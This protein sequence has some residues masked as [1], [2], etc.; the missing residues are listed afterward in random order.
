MRPTPYNERE[1]PNRWNPRKDKPEEYAV[2][3]RMLQADP[4]R[5]IP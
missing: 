5:V 3:S 1:D 4:T 2:K